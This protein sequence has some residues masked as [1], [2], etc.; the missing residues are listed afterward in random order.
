MEQWRDV[1]G[2]DGLYEVS[3]LG[4]VR[5]CKRNIMLTLFKS[6]KGYLRCELWKDSKKRKFG[7]H[8]I[9][10]LAWIPNDDVEKNQVNHI[11]EVK[12]DNRVEN[13][14]WCTNKYNNNYGHKNDNWRFTYYYKRG[15][16]VP[17]W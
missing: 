12:T 2:Y 1:V 4:R 16:E 14:E 13:L 6:N 3:N 17:L 15:R 9:V 11:N 10:A 8:R 5:S 7:V